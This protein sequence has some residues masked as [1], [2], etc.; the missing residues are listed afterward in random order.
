M[1][2]MR[3]WS[4]FLLIL[5]ATTPAGAQQVVTSARS[6]HVEGRASHPPQRHAALADDHSRHGS[7]TLRY[8]VTDQ[9]QS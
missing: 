2:P 3:A 7:A 5:L 8:R 9:D 6:E 1:R 4:P